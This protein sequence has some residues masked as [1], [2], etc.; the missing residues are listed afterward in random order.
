M[1]NLILR[2]NYSRLRNEV[3]VELHETTSAIIERFVPD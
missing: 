1:E 3:H 2:I